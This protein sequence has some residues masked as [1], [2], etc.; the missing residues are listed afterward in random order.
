MAMV[1]GAVRIG[2]SALTSRNMVE[3]DMEKVE[4]FH[5]AVEIAAVLQK[6]AGNK[7]L[8]DFVAKATTGEGEGRNLILR[9]V[10]GR[11]GPLPGVPDMKSIKNLT[12]L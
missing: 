11:A 1:P 2:T 7:L 12:D 9:S 4:L 10:S 5:M 3:S 6:K 8:K